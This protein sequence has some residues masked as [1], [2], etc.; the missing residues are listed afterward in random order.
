MKTF[1]YI[2]ITNF[3]FSEAD[4]KVIKGKC[5]CPFTFSSLRD[6]SQL[7]MLDSSDRAPTRPYLERK[8]KEG[9]QCPMIVTPYV[10]AEAT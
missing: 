3:V 9:S 10:L 1:L 7:K 2:L 8:L 4:E 5:V 6:M